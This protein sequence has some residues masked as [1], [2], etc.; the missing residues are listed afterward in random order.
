M[1]LMSIIFVVLAPYLILMFNAN[2]EVIRIGT[3]FLRITGLGTVFIAAGLIL[4]RSMSGAGDT[5][6]PLVITFITLWVIQIP[7][8][9][10]LSR[11]MG[12]NGVWLA[13]LI[14]YF[15]QAAMAISW[16]LVGRWKHKKV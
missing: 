1:L 15:S 9:F 3:N 13:I 11:F 2:P 8:A 5:K 6:S 14:A 4:G 7:L 10:F 12:L 16:F